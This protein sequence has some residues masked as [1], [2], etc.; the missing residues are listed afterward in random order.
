MSLSQQR[1]QDAVDHM[2]KTRE[3]EPDSRYIVS[4]KAYIFALFLYSSI[5]M[6]Y[7]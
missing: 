2:A 5:S 6:E 7:G 1:N 3:R 4:F